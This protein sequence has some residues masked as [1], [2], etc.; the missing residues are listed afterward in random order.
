MTSTWNPSDLAGATLSN[1]NLTV[2]TT[3]SGG[4]RSA[5][6]VTSGNYYWEVTV[7]TGI[8]SGTFGIGT[9]ATALSGATNQATTAT[10]SSTS[11]GIVVAGVS[12]TGL[13]AITNGSTICI[14]LTLGWP[15][16]IWFRNGAAGNWNGSSTANPATGVGGY[17]LSAFTGTGIGTYAFL[18]YNGSSAAFTANFG[19]SAFTGAVP[20]GFTSGFPS[21][22]SSTSSAVATQLAL[23][24]WASETTIQARLT[25]I[26]VEHW[27]SV[28]TLTPLRS[29]VG[30]RSFGRSNAS[31]L[32]AGVVLHG[33]GN[34]RSQTRAG[35][36]SLHI[37]IAGRLKAR[38]SIRASLPSTLVLAGRA[39]GRSAA[40]LLELGATIVVLGGKASAQSAA[41]T[42]ATV[43]ATRTRQYA[44]SVIN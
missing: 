23:E 13:G 19:G 28:Q 27:G 18:Q 20:S 34:A 21:G 39:S 37:D 33:T 14:A 30:T 10:V 3:A 2:S 1:G 5:D 9:A 8:A 35:P 12:Q 44:V 32:F 43:A 4:V 16:L 29:T 42:Y 24:Q 36:L 38:S 26:A 6:R 15:S 22:T 31:V 40:H 11:G 17:S 7:T 41:G 25:Q